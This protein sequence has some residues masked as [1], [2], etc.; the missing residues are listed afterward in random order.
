MANEMIRNQSKEILRIAHGVAVGHHGK[1]EAWQRIE[2]AIEG[3]QRPP[4]HE[5]NKMLGTINKIFFRN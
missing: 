3:V 5:I 1:K 4:Q 2:E